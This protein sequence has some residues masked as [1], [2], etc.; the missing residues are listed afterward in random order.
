MCK[1][2]DNL[3]ETKLLSVFLCRLQRI[4]AHRDRVVRRLSVCPVV[5]LSLKSHIAMFRR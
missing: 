4:A 2:W 5:K 1:K 3:V